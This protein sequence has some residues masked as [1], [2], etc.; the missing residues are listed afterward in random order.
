MDP[1]CTTTLQ[2]LQCQRG[3]TL[4]GGLDVGGSFGASCVYIPDHYVHHMKLLPRRAF[5]DC[6]HC[7]SVMHEDK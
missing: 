1:S 2:D 7:N 3:S 6:T 4:P 5:L